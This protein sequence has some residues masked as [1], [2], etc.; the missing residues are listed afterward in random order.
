MRRSWITVPVLAFAIV[1]IGDAGAAFPQMAGR[2][3]AGYETLL[4]LF[5]E[6]RTFQKPGISPEGVPDYS[7]AAM[8][9]QK[10]K[11]PEFQKRLAAISTQSWTIAQ[12]VDY[13]IVRAEMNGLD[14][15]HRVLRPWSRDPGFYVVIQNS[16][17]DVPAR[18]GAEIFGCLNLWEYTFPLDQARSSE[19]RRKLSAIPAILRQAKANLTE[20]ARDL[21]RLGARRKTSE[22]MALD[23]L[24]ERLS[25]TSPDLVP[26]ARQARAAVDD[27]RS[28]LEG[29]IPKLKG[30]SGIGKTEYDWYQKNVHLVPYSWDEQYRIAARELERSL[31]F[32][33]LEE[34]RNRKLPALQPPADSA[35]LQRRQTEAVATLFD[36]LRNNE[37]FTVADYMKLNAGGGTPLPPERRDFFTQ[38]DYRDPL[39]LKVHSIHWLEKQREARNQHPIRGTPLLYNIWDSRAEGFATAAEEIFLQAGL[40]DKNPRARELVY[41]LLAFR[42]VR[43]I[44]DLKLH[45]REWTV[46]EA[47][48]Y[49][50]A[51]TPYGWVKGDGDTIWGDLFIYLHGPGY[52][53][54]YVTGKVQVEGLMA[55]YAQLKGNAFT[56]KGF[57]D[58]MFARGLI[59]AS[60]IRWEMTG[61][62]DEMKKLGRN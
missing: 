13:E 11:L 53:T 5:S 16:E 36:F 31:S 62:D 27:F 8:A 6:F 9:A 60:L 18:E 50:A 1:T 21:W 57:L 48:K 41:I 3:D 34:V 61:L 19:M 12:R 49:A 29:A 52:G 30:P 56:L 4:K 33:K 26:L 24:A 15:D 25:A 46:D 7:A 58:D 32:L 39:P 42:A 35:E 23:R 22:A 51:T 2:A 20:D 14:F 55:D 54:S 40:Y 10:A 43:A 44:C 37:I 17:P 45:A 47:A 28:W 59:P 38:V